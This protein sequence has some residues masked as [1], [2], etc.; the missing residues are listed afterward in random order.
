MALRREVSGFVEAVA[1]DQPDDVLRQ[2]WQ[3]LN[4]AWAEFS[5]ALDAVRN[6]RIRA[7]AEGIDGS[8]LAVRDELQIAPSRHTGQIAR[9]AGSVDSLSEQLLVQ[10]RRWSRRDAS[11][12][13][14]EKAATAF[15]DRAHHLEDTVLDRA[16]PDHVLA[17]LQQAVAA[18]RELHPLLA[19][20]DTPEAP[21]L[22]HL[23]SQITQNL[24]QLQTL[25]TE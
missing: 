4:A 18:W 9:L 23:S 10:A 1:S 2:K 5:F 21:A 11:G 13:A 22:D 3:S 19:R 24:I 16:T 25:L 14:A 7:I 6:K 12:R 20:C 8:I 15:H 17:D